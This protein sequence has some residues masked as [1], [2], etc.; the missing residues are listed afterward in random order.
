MFSNKT[1]YALEHQVARQ[2]KC[3]ERK[4]S[5]SKKARR[6]SNPCCQDNDFS[7]TM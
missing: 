5:I 6:I 1:E 3:R 2:A 4:F 7:R